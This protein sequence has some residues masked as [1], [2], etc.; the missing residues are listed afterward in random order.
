MHSYVQAIFGDLARTIKVLHINSVTQT[1]KNEN[2]I[3]FEGDV[4]I[5]IDKSLHLWA[6][7]VTVYKDKRIMIAQSFPGGAVKL[8]DNS[9]LMLADRFELNVSKK[10]GNADNIRFHVDEGYF[11]A[12]KAE[13][14]NDLDWRL[15]N[16]FFTACG[17]PKPDWHIKADRAV[18]H[19]SY[20]VKAS[21][22]IF[23]VGKVPVFALPKFVFPIQGQS[24][25]GF[26]VPRFTFDYVYGFGVKQDYYRYFGPHC[27][28]TI[29]VD[30]QD[31]K[32]FVFSNEFRW[33]RS[34][35]DYTYMTG[36]YAV[37]RDR[38]VQ[39][40]NKVVKATDDHYWISGKDFRT[41]AGIGKDLDV[42]T[43]LRLDYGTD[44]RIGYYFFNN[45]D[46]VDDTFD[47]TL[48]VRLLSPNNL[49][50]FNVENA[51]TVTKT[52]QTLSDGNVLGVEDR[53]NL[54]Q[55]PHLEWNITQKAFK[56]LFY[57]QHTTFFD[58][59]LYRQEEIERKYV[60]AAVVSERESIPLRSAQVMRFTYKGFLS[61]VL[62]LGHNNISIRAEPTL[63]VVSQLAQDFVVSKNVF[64]QRALGKGGYRLFCEYG[65]EW[66][67][68]EGCAYTRDGRY[69]HAIQPMLTWSMNPRFYQDNWFYFDKWDR[70]YPKNELACLIRNHW[71][72]D[73][74]DM[75]LDIKQACDFYRR[76]DW[77]SLRRGVKQQ[78]LLPFS[79][80]FQLGYQNVQASLIQEYEWGHFNLLQSEL[81]TM[82]MVKRVQLGV[83]YLFQRQ[84][85]ARQRDLLSTIPHFV[86]ATIAIPL[87]KHATLSYEGQFYAAGRSSFFS[88]DGITP[89][90][91][92][93]RLDYDGHCWG[94]Y[95]GLE[96]KKFKEYGI[97]RDERAVVFSFRLNSLGSFAKKFKKMPQMMRNQ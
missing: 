48:K 68:P 41:F 75:N 79:Y 64:Q 56:R 24:K 54:S 19:G 88:F 18:V 49:V 73:Q 8:E 17:S 27:D 89:L 43:L 31:K 34:V 55:V 35:Q 72:I 37:E 62:W 60:Q 21:G 30:W 93:I 53:L 12:G 97:G 1:I 58:Q 45:I 70:A 16:M 65:A 38:F 78:H 51:K 76:S 90:I 77:F 80:D 14:I 83:G 82:L 46:Q 9:F 15:E 96:E 74:L 95:V 42:N 67:M 63:Q 39:K 22:I 50:T 84:D 11:S 10:T 92:R 91:H 87:G 4:E 85:L 71:N 2:E 25:S 47:N 6:D 32:G 23:K 69:M 81:N 52:Y 36:Q 20:F 3:V 7:R 26:L 61:N 66:A 33:A 29:G 13:K 57:Y 40:N 28:T 5:V 94:F 59:I 44:K 86:T